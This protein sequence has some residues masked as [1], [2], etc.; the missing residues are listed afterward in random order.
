MKDIQY[1][2]YYDEDYEDKIEELKKVSN[3]KKVIINAINYFNDDNIKLYISTKKNKKFMIKNPE[4]KWISF[5]QMNPPMEDYTKHQD[6]DR[7]DA[8]LARATKIK[9]NWS[10]NKY[11]PNRL[12]ISL[13]CN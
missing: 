2:L 13:L 1:R 4:G 11:S 6:K 7:R 3:I 10:S 8:Y 12:S 9:G 5:G